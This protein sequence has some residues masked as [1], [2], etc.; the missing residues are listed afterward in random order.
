[1][2]KSQSSA[3]KTDATSSSEGPS[4]AAR[5]SNDKIDLS[6]LKGHDANVN[7]K[8]DRITFND[9]S[10]DH[11]NLKASL[12]KTGQLKISQL[13]MK[14]LDG[15]LSCTGD[16]DASSHR[17]SLSPQID[18]INLAKIPSLKET[19]LKGGT[20][21]ASGHLTTSLTSIDAAVKHLSG[22]FNITVSNGSA[23]AFDVKQFINDVKKVKDLSGLTSLKDG[24]NRKAIVPFKT[25]SAVTDSHEGRCQVTSFRLEINEGTVNG[26]GMIDLKAWSLDLTTRIQINDLGKIPPLGLFIRGSLDAPAFDIDQ[27]QLQHVL[28]QG[29]ANKVVDKVKDR[30][31]DQI[32]GKLGVKAP[33]HQDDAAA[34]KVQP[35]RNSHNPADLVGQL[36]PGLKGLI[37]G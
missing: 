14:G 6:P 27:A 7:L 32:L 3:P 16:I 18:H 8:V 34:P 28:I 21:Q 9:Y 22:P 1:V 29:V 30:I 24:L 26:S 12:Q 10:F 31:Q 2:Y 13:S 17:L 5:F 35:Q 19:P 25:I 36:V 33:N 37:G 4:S 15:A 20:L 11:M 23:E